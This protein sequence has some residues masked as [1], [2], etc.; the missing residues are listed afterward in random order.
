MEKLIQL[1][2]VF[3]VSIQIIDIKLVSVPKF[4]YFCNDEQKR[5]THQAISDIA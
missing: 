5:E 2:H 3:Y 1:I 4:S